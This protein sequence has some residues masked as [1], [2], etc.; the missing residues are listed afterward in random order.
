M[1]KTPMPKTPSDLVRGMPAAAKAAGIS[2]STLARWV[3]AGYIRPS[4]KY[5]SKVVMYSVAKVREFAVSMGLG[6]Q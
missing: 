1:P 6:D 2:V 4:R 5:N 3:K